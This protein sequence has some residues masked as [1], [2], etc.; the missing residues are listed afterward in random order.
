M[1]NNAVLIR[2]LDRDLYN[3][4]ISKAK[5]QGKNVADLVNEACGSI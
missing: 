4:V 3:N 1:T 5:Q 2:G